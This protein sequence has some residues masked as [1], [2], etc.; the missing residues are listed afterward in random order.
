[1]CQ[2]TRKHTCIGLEYEVM[3][4]G[5]PRIYCEEAIDLTLAN[6]GIVYVVRHL[7]PRALDGATVCRQVNHFYVDGVC[8]ECGFV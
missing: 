1:M 5:K 6:S 2:Y 4:N 8:A 7:T 3:R